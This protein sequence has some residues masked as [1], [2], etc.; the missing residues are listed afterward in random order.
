MYYVGNDTQLSQKS[1]K[2]E[3]SR[4]LGFAISYFYKAVNSAMVGNSKIP[5]RLWHVKTNRN[6]S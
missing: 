4:F 3:P 5:D 1:G 6:S 2:I